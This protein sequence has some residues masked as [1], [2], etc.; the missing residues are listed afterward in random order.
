MTKAKSFE[1]SI[2]ALE[3]IVE[4]LEN[5]EITLEDSIKQYKEGIK[6]VNHCNDAIDKIEKELEIVAEEKA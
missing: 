4:S 6:L 2:G 5:D 1:A 3:K